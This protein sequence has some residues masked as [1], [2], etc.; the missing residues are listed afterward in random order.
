M[1]RAARIEL[2]ADLLKMQA[3][4]NQ[5]QRLNRDNSAK[6][7]RDATFAYRVDLAKLQSDLRTAE[8]EHAAS[9][10][11]MGQQSGGAGGGLGAV[12][13][14]LLTGVGIGSGAQLAQTGIALLGSAV[15]AGKRSFIDY[16]SELETTKA[17]LQALTGSST[18]ATAILAYLRKEADDTAFSF[19]DFSSSI[20][21]LVPIS[22]QS[23][24]ALNDLIKTT[25][26]L[27]TLN[28]RV[29][30]GG[31][32]QGA[33]IALANA[34]AG[35]FQSLRDRFNVNLTAIQRYREQGMSN[36]DAIRAGLKDLGVDETLVGNLSL[37]FAGRLS[38][39]QDA[40]ASIAGRAGEPIFDLGK[41]G[42]TSLS[43]FLQS[44]VVKRETQQISAD[45]KQMVDDLKSY[46]SDPELRKAG[47]QSSVFSGDA[48]HGVSTLAASI[49]DELG[50]VLKELPGFVATALGSANDF[51]KALTGLNNTVGA[52]GA[53]LNVLIKQTYFLYLSKL[54]ANRDELKQLYD[55]IIQQ[56]QKID[57]VKAGKPGEA[58]T[59]GEAG[60]PYGPPV[61]AATI[62]GP[63]ATQ[64]K[65][66]TERQRRAFLD[67][68]AELQSYLRGFTSQSNTILSA[69]Q[70]QLQAQFER[71]YGS[72]STDQQVEKGL[73]RIP[74]LAAKITDEVRRYGAVSV[75]TGNQV[76][77]ILGGQADDVLRLADAYGKLA[78]LQGNATR[79]TLASGAAA[80][81]VATVTA[82]ADAAIK[83]A[84]GRVSAAEATARAHATASQ[85]EAQ[86][87]QDRLGAIGREADGVARGYDARLRELQGGLIALGR[88]AEAVA[89][90]YDDEL[91]GLQSTLTGLSRAADEAQ[92]AF[93][94][95]LRAAQGEQQAAQE[96]ATRNAAAYGAV[97]A[98]TTD[99]YLRQNRALSD[100]ERQIIANGNAQVRAALA[101]K[102]GADAEVRALEVRQR[103]D[104]LRLNEQIR[105]AR[106]PGGAGEGAAR[107]LEDQRNLVKARSEYA[108][109]LARQRAA[110]RGDEADTAKQPV[111]EAAKA[112]ADADKQRTDAASAH[113]ADIQEQA[114][115]QADADRDA[116]Q[117]L[118]DQIGAVQEQAR[119]AAQLYADR[120]RA[121]SDQIAAV[122]EEARQ[123]AEMYAERQRGIAEEIRLVNE[124]ARVQATADRDAIDG[125][126]TALGLVKQIED[127]RIRAAQRGATIAQDA[128]N[129]ANAEYLAQ[130]NV[131]TAMGQKQ[132]ALDTYLRSWSDFISG[133]RGQGI[134]PAKFFNGA[135]VPSIAGQPSATGGGRDAR[136][137]GSGASGAPAPSQPAPSPGL[138]GTYSR[139][140]LPSVAFT[141]LPPLDYRAPAPP[142]L[143]NVALAGMGAGAGLPSL[144]RGSVGNI[145]LTSTFPN[146]QF[147][148]DVDVKRAVQEG[149]EAGL[150]S[151]LAALND[152]S[153]G[154]GALS[155]WRD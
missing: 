114:R 115:Q 137:D 11:R 77:A 15:G 58:P 72:L 23:G 84:E 43:A 129:A 1:Q 133:L 31:G 81:R 39:L 155:G 24:V 78:G 68:Q 66:A 26:I 87:L 56:Q 74:V 20:A 40:L 30:N 41:S 79:A 8:R 46:L 154:G 93:A 19:Q 97:L 132:A 33:A 128:A 106:Q 92:R 153:A 63:P 104:L 13:D 4:F 86:A 88:E 148:S 141:P 95:Q 111:E 125:A 17:Q 70:P 2:R 110:V 27:A 118:Q 45:F 80:G 64:Q 145:T 22:R 144:A 59:N 82:S 67:G 120:Q 94:A 102:T 150:R 101:A 14:A 6:L 54:G 51:A 138:P 50:P 36:V 112:Q 52:A 65:G 42:I 18:Q 5:A 3:D 48:A 131:L 69:V 29:E 117:A 99:E 55:D 85:D 123:A 10:K 126:T 57:A 96:A 119:T 32:F 124:R 108:L 62:A 49:K 9:L 91:R 103:A 12:G 71:L 139:A 135:T 75:D 109:D 152:D 105:A 37:T 38:T 130:Q 16:N 21:A 100:Q 151:F 90:R 44:D 142:A 34:D 121:A 25:E 83:G 7:N 116:Q 28:P 127:A 147:T 61:P 143:S 98:G 35:D 76:R 149:Q 113:V 89:R 107:A 73:G 134:D 47:E 60:V 136:E 53:Q 146:A 140:P 122:Q